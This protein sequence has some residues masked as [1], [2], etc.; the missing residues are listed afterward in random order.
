MKTYSVTGIQPPGRVNLRLG[1][2]FQEVNLHDLSQQQLAE[3][4]AAGC[5]FVRVTEAPESK[6]TVTPPRQVE[7]VKNKPKKSY[8]K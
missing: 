5:E 4:Y 6:S 2:R 7:I 1:G 3:L 8:R